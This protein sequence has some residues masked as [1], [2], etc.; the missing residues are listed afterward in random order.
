MNDITADIGQLKRQLR[1]VQA[2]ASNVQH[3][4]RRLVEP[5]A[6]VARLAWQLA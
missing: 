5:E 1:D 2:T 4:V 6:A 3:L